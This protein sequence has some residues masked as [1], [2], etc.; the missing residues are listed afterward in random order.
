MCYKR[1]VSRLK[2]LIKSLGEIEISN[3]LLLLE[4]EQNLELTW[5]SDFLSA[6]WLSIVCY[7]Q[8]TLWLFAFLNC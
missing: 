2:K 7:I 4:K 6:P 3:L 5:D 8:T 1:I